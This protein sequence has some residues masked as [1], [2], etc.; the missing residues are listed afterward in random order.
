M[1][2]SF[3]QIILLSAYGF[4]AIWDDLNPGFKLGKPVV[5]GM[6]AGLIMGDIQ[7]GLLVGG[8]LQLMILGVGTYGGA[9]IPDYM[10]GAVVGTAFAVSSGKGLE[11]AL[12]IAVPVGLLMV[13]LDVLGRFC[14]TYFQH[15]ADKGAEQRNYRKVELGNVLGMI[16]WGLSRALPIFL[17]LFFGQD[18]V[19]TLLD[20]SPEWLMNGLKTAGGLLPALGIAILL[21]YMP[22]KTYWMY[23]IAGFVAATYL[24]VPMLGVALVGLVAAGVAYARSDEPAVSAVVNEG[25]TIEDDE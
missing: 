25:G 17:A 16:P 1:E 9:S 18:I 12:A 22:L 3:L 20:N 19:K 14:N 23:A 2:I 24:K 5:A 10:T 6:F 4:I 15:M 21:R 8:T 11:Y 13:Q 7:M